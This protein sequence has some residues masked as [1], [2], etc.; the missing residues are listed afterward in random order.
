MTA[1]KPESV[2]MFPGSDRR[3]EKEIDSE[4]I[5]ILEKV[6][7]QT[8]KMKKIENVSVNQRHIGTGKL[9]TLEAEP[10][11]AIMATGKQGIRPRILPPREC[12]RAKKMSAQTWAAQP[13]RGAGALLIVVK[14]TPPSNEAGTSMKSPTGGLHCERAHHGTCGLSDTEQA[15]CERQLQWGPGRNFSKWSGPP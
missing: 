15:H 13:G 3:I 4:K 14:P 9:K 8:L 11:P 12:K 6:H 5:K 7:F 10:S 1:Q 2:G